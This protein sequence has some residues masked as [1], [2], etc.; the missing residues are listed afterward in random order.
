MNLSWIQPVIWL[1]LALVVAAML[2]GLLLAFRRKRRQ[3]SAPP[4][5]PRKGWG[6]L[7]YAL[8]LAL[9]AILSLL[10]LGT[11]LLVAMDYNEAKNETAPARRSVS[12]PPGLPFQ[13]QEVTFP[14]G[15][16]IQLAG[17]YVP[18]RN[19]ATVILL[20]GY[21]GSRLGMLWHA[22]TLVEAGY[23]VLLYDERASG[24]SGGARRSFGWEDASDVAGAVA[25]L[26]TRPGGQPAH[27]GIAGCSM[28]AQIALQGAIQNPEIG[29]VWADGPAVVAASDN[30]PPDNAVKRLFYLSNQLLDLIFQYHLGIRPPAPLI[31]TIGQI[32]PRP[33][34]LVGGGVEMG[35]LGSEAERLN[36]YAAHAGPNA[37][38]WVIDDVVHCDGPSKRS[39]EYAQ[40]FVDFYNEAFGLQR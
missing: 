31:D 33:L 13:P 14:G 28:G 39:D 7:V 26:K 40:R 37:R 22:Q 27:I 32:A 36:W 9:F 23:G 11:V 35:M 4:E 12:I 17:W 10:F 34:M 30:E 5:S 21:G 6:K 3:G 29:A 20:H 24:E 8:R 18:A 2:G 25:Y 38:V 19:G 15:D 16:G 1:T